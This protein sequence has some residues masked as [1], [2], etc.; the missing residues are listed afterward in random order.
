MIRI[1]LRNE[2]PYTG[3]HI[4][5]YSSAACL[6]LLAAADYSAA[7]ARAS[8][9]AVAAIREGSPYTGFHSHV[10]SSAACLRL[11][12]AAAYSAAAARASAVAVAAAEGHACVSADLRGSSIYCLA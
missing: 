6:R 8:A 7:A 4:H 1:L 3:F 10:C 12:A 2:L 11:P 5:V 9:V